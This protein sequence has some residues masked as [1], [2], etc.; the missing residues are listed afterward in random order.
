M[1]IVNPLQKECNCNPFSAFLVETCEQMEVHGF[2]SCS[3]CKEGTQFI[4]YTKY[5]Q[6]NG[7]DNQACEQLGEFCITV[8]AT[9]IS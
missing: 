9:L 8:V 1:F 3:I 4:A 5:D 6:N 7:T 2:C